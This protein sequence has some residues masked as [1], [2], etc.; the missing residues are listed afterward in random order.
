MYWCII[1]SEPKGL[2]TVKWHTH[3][4]MRRQFTL[5][6]ATTIRGISSTRFQCLK[7]LCSLC[8]YAHN[9]FIE[10]NDYKKDFGTKLFRRTPHVNALPKTQIIHVGGEN[11][12]SIH[13]VHTVHICSSKR[14]KLLP[15]CTTFGES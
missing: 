12:T 3:R 7:E 4:K 9:S 2:P 13:V 14:L 15:L 11:R 5:I 1:D 10:V 8:K 6:W